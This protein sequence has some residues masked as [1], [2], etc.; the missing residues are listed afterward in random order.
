MCKPEFPWILQ[1]FDTVWALDDNYDKQINYSRHE[2]C[3]K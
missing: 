2:E 3:P 1:I